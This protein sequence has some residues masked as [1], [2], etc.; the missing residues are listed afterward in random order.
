[1]ERSPVI[2]FDVNFT[3]TIWSSSRYHG[4]PCQYKSLSVVIIFA[5]R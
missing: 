5:H 1:M 3:D 4:R 2:K